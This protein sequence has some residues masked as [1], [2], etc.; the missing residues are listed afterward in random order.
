M[1]PLLEHG[2]HGIDLGA[3]GAPAKG[4]QNAELS[5]E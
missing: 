5:P 4:Q 2:L 3:V 1:S